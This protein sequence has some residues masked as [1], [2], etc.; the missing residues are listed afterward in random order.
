MIRLTNIS[1]NI[2]QLRIITISQS[3]NGD[4]PAV[5]VARLNVEKQII[6]MLRLIVDHGDPVSGRQRLV[7]Q[8]LIRSQIFSLSVSLF[9][10]LSTG[11]TSYQLASFDKRAT[12]LQAG[13]PHD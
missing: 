11:M 6:A 12:L 5:G 13:R 8:R 1:Y 10:A 9:Q 2:K 7:K 4:G 3:S